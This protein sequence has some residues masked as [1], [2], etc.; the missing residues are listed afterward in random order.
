MLHQIAMDPLGSV[1]K[2]KID[3]FKGEGLQGPSFLFG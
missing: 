1:S 3:I 2:C